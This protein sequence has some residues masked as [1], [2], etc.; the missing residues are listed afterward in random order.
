ML[1][2]ARGLA[3]DPSVLLLDEPSMGLAPAIVDD[4]FERIQSLRAQGTLT[5]LLAEQRAV[6]ALESCDSGLVLQ[7]G[8]VALAGSRKDLIESPRIKALYLGQ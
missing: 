6:E 2:I 1:A 4:I 5:V 8:R 7:S 3:S